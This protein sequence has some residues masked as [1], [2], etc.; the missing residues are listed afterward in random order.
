MTKEIAL[1]FDFKL[2]S[3]DN[4]KIQNRN[5]KYFLSKKYKDFEK[6]IKDSTF[7]QMHNN[8]LDSFAPGVQLKM[9]I[10]AYFKTKV[11]ADMWNLPKSLSD[12]LQGIVYKNDKQ[13]KAG[14]ISITEGW[15][16]DKFT[17]YVNQ[18]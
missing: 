14:T 12:A 1:E 16:E 9:E 6:L 8:K 4:E 13:I 15:D 5:G 10:F 18:L 11:H 2:I 17:V 7:V 3:K